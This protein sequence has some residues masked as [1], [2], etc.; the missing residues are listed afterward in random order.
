MPLS[1][2]SARPCRAAG[3]ARRCHEAVG[4]DARPRRAAP[5]GRSDRPSPPRNSW[6]CNTPRYRYRSTATTPSATAVASFVVGVGEH[7]EEEVLGAS[8]GVDVRVITNR[9]Q[10][11]DVDSD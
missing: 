11:L 7:L 1:G 2:R 4:S 3:D 10:V 5:V 6:L 9:A 8:S